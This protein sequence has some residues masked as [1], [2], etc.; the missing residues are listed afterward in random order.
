[1]MEELIHS[2]LQTNPLYNEY[3]DC[4]FLPPVYRKMVSKEFEYVGNVRHL[5]GPSGI[6]HPP[7]DWPTTVTIIPE[8]IIYTKP[9]RGPALERKYLLNLYS[10]QRHTESDLALEHL[11]EAQVDLKSQ[12]PICEPPE[13]SDSLPSPRHILSAISNMKPSANAGYPFVR[14]AMGKREFAFENFPHIYHLVLIRLIS[15]EYLFRPDD[16]P[17]DLVRKFCVDPVMAMIKN[18]ILKFGKD[19]RMIGMT[20]I[21]SELVYRIAFDELSHHSVECWGDFYSC[22]G[23]GFTSGASNMLHEYFDGVQI[24]KSDVPKF[25]MT[26][27]VEEAILDNDLQM[28]QLRIPVQSRF[29]RVYHNFTIAGCKSIFVFTDGVLWAQIYPGTTKSGEKTTG[30]RNTATRARRSYAVARYMKEP[31]NLVRNAGDDAIERHYPGKEQGYHDLGFPLRDYE[32][33]VGD[34]DFCSHFFPK[35]KRPVGQRILKSVAGL[36]YT[37]ETSSERLASFVREFANHPEFSKYFCK[38][39]SARPR[40]KLNNL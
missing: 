1:M 24:A 29:Y 8:I 35:G 20:S 40:I 5:G 33:V 9:D 36:L 27:S 2:S 14:S 6:S 15:L 23:M 3:Y 25:D 34:I 30:E 39:L 19:P 31:E 26:R 16:S 7:D 18:E 4:T 13:W 10:H 32:V 38:I 11:F 17:L 22:I 28:F 37:R 12:V 21:V